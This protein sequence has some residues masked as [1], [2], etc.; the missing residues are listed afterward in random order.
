[1]KS[2][3][4]GLFVILII[5]LLQIINVRLVLKKINDHVERVKLENIRLLDLLTDL[6]HELRAL[7]YE[8]YDQEDAIEKDEHN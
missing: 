7:K 3:F 6:E 5:I 1:M 8:D 4:I 2:E